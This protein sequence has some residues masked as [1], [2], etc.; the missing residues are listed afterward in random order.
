MVPCSRRTTYLRKYNLGHNASLPTDHRERS[1]KSTVFALAA[2]LCGCTTQATQEPAS[3]AG[4]QADARTA[5]AAPANPAQSSI[6]VASGASN[7]KA[8]PT[9]RGI[10]YPSDQAE[11]TGES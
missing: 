9:N 10:N 3:S 8:V 11:I 2:I 4:A 1:M 5:Q 6:S 7:A